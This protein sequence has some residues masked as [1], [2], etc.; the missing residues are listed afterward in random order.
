MNIYIYPIYDRTTDSN[1]IESIKARSL[2]E[3]FEKLSDEYE[4]D[5]ICE[6][7]LEFE[8]AM[9]AYDFTVGSLTDIE[10]IT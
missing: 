8:K 5:E 4:L 2:K 1:S 6:N 3:A 7:Q 9:D 10:E